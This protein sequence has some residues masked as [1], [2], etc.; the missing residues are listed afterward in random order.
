MGIS[1]FILKPLVMDNLARTVR[2]ALD[3]FPSSQNTK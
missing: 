2:S 1:E 3:R